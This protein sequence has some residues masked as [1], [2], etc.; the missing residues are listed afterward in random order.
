MNVI[1]EAVVAPVFLV[2]RLLLVNQFNNLPV[3]IV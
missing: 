2:E 1:K 3:F